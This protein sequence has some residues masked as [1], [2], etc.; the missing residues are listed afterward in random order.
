M[1]PEMGDL[2]AALPRELDEP[3]TTRDAL[4]DLLVKLSNKP[5]PV[6]SINRLW[7]LGGMQAKIVLGYVAYYIRSS[8]V[9]KDEKD[10]RKNEAHLTAALKLLSGMGYMRG[11]IMKIGQLLAA[12]PK[13]MPD[14]FA[15]TLSSLNFSAPP[16]HYSLLREML[17]NELGGDPADI[18]AEFETEAFAA[19][20]LGQVHR[21]R[22]KTGEQVAVKVQYPNI[23]RTIRDDVRNMSAFMLPMRLS[24]DWE[25]LKEQ[26]EEVREVLEKE[27]D[28]RAEAESLKKAHAIFENEPDIVVPRVY[29]QFSTDRV[30]TMDYLDG[31]HLDDYLKTNP[32]QD[33]RNHYGTLLNRQSFMLYYR[34]KMLQAD[35]NVGNFL[36]MPDGRLGLIDFGCTRP[37]TEEEWQFLLDCDRVVKGSHEEWIPVLERSVAMDNLQEK[38]PEYLRMLLDLG[39]WLWRPLLTE[40]EFDFAGDNYFAEGMEQ[41]AEFTRRRYIRGIPIQNWLN[42]TFV[43]LRAILYRLRSRVDVKSI[44]DAERTNSKREE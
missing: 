4:R 37:F 25:N 39:E 5:V 1:S 36:F 30:I 3:T 28:Y 27:T 10:R 32:S 13:V 14:E 29:E 43:G 6:G 38:N 21:A 7:A 16:M 17:K 22:L 42:R 9:T 2:V 44:Y 41:Y 35:P 20:S 33:D 24:G 19:A 12:Y 8:Y 15:E 34:G 11:A 23:A 40:G 26:L 18:F 31:V